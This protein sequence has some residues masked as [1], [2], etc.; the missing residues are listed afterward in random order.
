MDFLCPFVYYIIYCCRVV[1][2]SCFYEFPEMAFV[3]IPVGLFMTFS[4]FDG[5][6]DWTAGYFEYYWDMVTAGCWSGVCMAIMD[7]PVVS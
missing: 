4:G 3:A 5:D 6:K 1:E 7:Y 2:N